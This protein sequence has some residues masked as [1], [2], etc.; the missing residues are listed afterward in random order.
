MTRR[1]MSLIGMTP[2]GRPEP[3]YEESGPVPGSTVANYWA[4][5]STFKGAFGVAVSV[6]D[7]GRI[8]DAEATRL[9]HYII[10][11]HRELEEAFAASLR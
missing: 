2:D 6:S 5:V 3:V 10:K 9:N 8:D 4:K 7:P 1:S 11:K